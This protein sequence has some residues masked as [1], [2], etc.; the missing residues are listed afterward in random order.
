MENGADPRKV[1]RDSLAEYRKRR[2]VQS[3]VGTP[4]VRS[5]SGRGYSG[6]YANG[7]EKIALRA[8]TAGL[9]VSHGIRLIEDRLVRPLRPDSRRLGS[10]Q[11][12]AVA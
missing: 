2:K 6:D 9:G 3:R 5:D 4:L 12:G 1:E 8:E 11:R 10:P 7:G